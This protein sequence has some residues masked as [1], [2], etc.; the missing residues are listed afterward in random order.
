MD[1][2]TG[3]GMAIWFAAVFARAFGR[4]A[5]HQASGFYAAAYGL[6]SLNDI[7]IGAHIAAVVSAAMC[8]FFAY[9]W[10]RG[11]GG[12]GTKRRLRAL[13]RKFSDVRRTAPQLT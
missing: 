9:G 6:W 5:Y 3:I 8:A 4:I 13:R 2:L 11:G 10:W 7:R 12:D 1:L